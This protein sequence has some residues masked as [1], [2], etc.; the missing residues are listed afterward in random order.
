MTVI[1]KLII[2]FLSQQIVVSGPNAH[3]IVGEEDSPFSHTA[4]ITLT[5]NRDDNPYFISSTV[6]VGSKSIAIFGNVRNSK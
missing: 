1:N 4:T 6:R 5:G 2:V 3:L